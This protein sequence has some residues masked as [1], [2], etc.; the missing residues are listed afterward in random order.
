MRILLQIIAIGLASNAGYTLFDKGVSYVNEFSDPYICNGKIINMFIDI[1]NTGEYESIQ[2]TPLMLNICPTL[3]QSCCNSEVL[4]NLMKNFLEGKKNLW[5]I[6]DVYDETIKIFK[7]K[8]K[9]IKQLTSEKTIEI[10]NSCMGDDNV[11]S[12]PSYISRV[13]N[14]ATTMRKAFVDLLN[15]IS[16]FYSGFA[17]ELCSGSFPSQFIVKD[18]INKIKYNIS[19]AHS[20][21]K[22]LSKF[23]PIYKFISDYSRVGKAAYCLKHDEANKF[24]NHMSDKNYEENTKMLKRCMELSP[25]ETIEDVQCL[26]IIRKKGYTNDFRIFEFLYPIM[27]LTKMALTNIEENN[28]ASL[29]DAE[30]YNGYV[31]F[32]PLNPNSKPSFKDIKLE[33]SISEGIKM[34][35]NAMN[36]SLWKRV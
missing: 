3:D 22:I 19:N 15:E 31:V 33:Y 4:V 14:E 8:S 6:L 10:I 18:K 9:S 35:D 13:E 21:L 20:L 29:V 25:E 26:K 17:C 34:T 28:V 27:N 11:F 23:Y 36:E 2:P 5:K 32:Y 7:L 12:L 30:D 1:P 24:E 16:K